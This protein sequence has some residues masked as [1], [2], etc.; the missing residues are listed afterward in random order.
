MYPV[1]KLEALAV[2]FSYAYTA[3]GRNVGQANSLTIGAALHVQRSAESRSMT[4]ARN[5]IHWVLAAAMAF[6][7]V[8]RRQRRHHR[9]RRRHVADDRPDRAHAGPSRASGAGQ[10][11]RL[12]GGVSLDQVRPEPAH[13]R[14]APHH[15]LLERRRRAALERADAPAG[16]ARQPA[17]GAESRRHVPGAGRDQPLRGPAYF[18]SPTRRTP[19]APTATSPS[20]ST[21]R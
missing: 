19:R 14:A 3:T 13:Q 2:Q 4:A 10:Q 8:D 18:R 9:S 20:R 11:P 21:K 15:R 5:H 6:A 12:P 17:S 7:P 1:P 16:S